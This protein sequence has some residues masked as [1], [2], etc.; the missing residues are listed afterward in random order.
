MKK[1]NELKNQK[2]DNSRIVVYGLA[3]DIESTPVIFVDTLE[4]VEW[5][6]KGDSYTKRLKIFRYEITEV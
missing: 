2:V 5:Y 1:T 3:K 6:K 4:G